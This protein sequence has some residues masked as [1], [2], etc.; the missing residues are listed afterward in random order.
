MSALPQAIA[1]YTLHEKIQLVEDIWDNIA[2][3]AATARATSQ[4]AQAASLPQHE[5][6]RTKRPQRCSNR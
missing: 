4:A 6:R 5:D 2:E 1:D 3:E